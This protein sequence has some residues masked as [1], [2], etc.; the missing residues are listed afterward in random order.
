[1]ARGP[2]LLW[3]RVLWGGWPR[4]SET[5][6]FCPQ[7]DPCEPK[8]SDANEEAVGDADRLREQWTLKCEAE[9]K[10]QSRQ[11]KGRAHPPQRCREE[12]GAHGQEKQ[13]DQHRDRPR[14]DVD[15]AERHF[16]VAAI[17]LVGRPRGGIANSSTPTIGRT[18]ATPVMLKTNA[19]N[20]ATRQRSPSARTE[21]PDR[22]LT[23]AGS[24]RMFCGKR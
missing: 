18:R 22:R 19:Y 7:H 21:P 13:A 1:M 24:G 14:P 5:T 17:W 20:A 6:H 15:L 16:N 11:S 3:G 2:W 10:D 4:F 12:E 23:A 8:A 9:S